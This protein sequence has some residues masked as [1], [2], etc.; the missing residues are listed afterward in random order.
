[1]GGP[2]AW[3]QTEGLQYCCQQCPQL[4]VVFNGVGPVRC[5]YRCRRGCWSCLADRSEALHGAVQAGG[6]GISLGCW[7]PGCDCSR[8][9]SAH[10][11]QPPLSRT[12]CCAGGPDHIWLLPIMESQQTLTLPVVCFHELGAGWLANRTMADC[13][14]QSAAGGKRAQSTG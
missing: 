10:A 1:M 4:I 2:C 6:P 14:L 12:L 7:G 3:T 5:T 11:A 13:G 8:S 9:E